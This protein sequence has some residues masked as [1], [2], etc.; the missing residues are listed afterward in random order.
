M[1]RRLSINDALAEIAAKGDTDHVA[2]DHAPVEEPP[3]AQAPT[4]GYTPDGYRIR[5][6]REKPHAS[7]YAHPRVFDV[8]KELA[9]AQRKRPHDLYIEGLRLM[10]ARYGHDFDKLDRGEA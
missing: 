10:L 9:A 2:R 7:L 3:A 6:R 5:V 1:T 8:I 4:S